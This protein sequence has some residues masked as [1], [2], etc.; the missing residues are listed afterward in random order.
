MPTT[1]SQS[2]VMS[3][4]PISSILEEPESPKSTSSQET[5]WSTQSINSTQKLDN[6]L[7]PGWIH[8]ITIIMGK[9]LKSEV[10]QMLQ[11]W[12]Q[13]HLIHCHTEFWF[14]WDP[15][16]PEDFRLLQNYDGSIAYL[17]SNLAKNLV[18]LWDFMNLLTKQ[19]RPDGENNKLYYLMDEQWTK[20]TA[21][22]MRSALIDDKNEKQNSHMSPAAPS[23][24]SHLRSPT[25][26]LPVTSPS[27]LQEK[28]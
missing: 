19:D 25:S 3:T 18:S 21:H 23:H 8:A 7:S 5:P 12:I 13:Y 24:M 26:P 20:L 28:Y 6:L 27:I 22:D 9:S 10:G 17:P 4:S 2:K 14:S 16:D 1:R 11:K 15:S